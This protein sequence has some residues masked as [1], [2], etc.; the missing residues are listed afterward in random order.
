M[1]TAWIFEDKE[2]S[3]D[4]DLD[5]HV[6]FVYL[7]TNTTK[8]KYY[9]GKKLFRHRKTFQKNLKRR[10][11]LV[12]SDW[13]DYV[14]SSETLQKDVADGDHL[15]KEILHLCTS[16]GWMSY[17]E[18]LEILKRNALQ[19]ENYYNQWVSAKIHAKHLK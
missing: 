9:V 8:S 19:S 1:K 6:G 16:K 18:T 3:L 17:I 15:V 10:F 12:E 14:G 7:I 2:F 13:Q 5:K 11:K 4:L